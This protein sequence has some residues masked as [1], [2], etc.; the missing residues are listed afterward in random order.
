MSALKS[1]MVVYG[2]GNLS[3]VTYIKAKSAEEAGQTVMA[4]LQN[5]LRLGTARVYSV[6]PD[7]TRWGEQFS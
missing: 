3:G 6:E 7:N 1:W 2:H 4:C 5:R